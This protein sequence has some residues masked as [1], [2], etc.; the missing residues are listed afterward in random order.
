MQNFSFLAAWKEILANLD[1]F[2][3]CYTVQCV[4]HMATHH[5]HTT[6]MNIFLPHDNQFMVS[7]ENFK[8]QKTGKDEKF[9]TY[10][11]FQVISLEICIF[12]NF[13]AFL[14]L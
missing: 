10:L 6:K 1:Q 12:A 14:D 3:E 7:A 5:I 4:G 11:R 13:K 8:P 9:Y 2:S